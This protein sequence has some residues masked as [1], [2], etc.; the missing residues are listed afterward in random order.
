MEVW[1]REGAWSDFRLGA[2][3][4]IASGEGRKKWEMRRLLPERGW[5]LVLECEL[6]KKAHDKYG[7]RVIEPGHPPD[8]IR[9]PQH[10]PILQIAEVRLGWELFVPTSLF[11]SGL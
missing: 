7:Q 10:P 5:Q 6:G 2:G 8:G 4:W 3:W 11:S 1:S 9:S